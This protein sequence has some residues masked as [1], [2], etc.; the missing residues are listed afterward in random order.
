MKDI[1][2]NAVEQ[3][4]KRRAQK[5]ASSI[6]DIT[7]QNTLL[8][9]ENRGFKEALYH[10]QKRR[11]RGKQLFEEFRAQEGGG[12]IFFSPNKIQA[13]KELQIQ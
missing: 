9:I 2:R 5:I 1:V 7:T 8:K 6:V 10:E 13:A 3:S 12:A 11:K 4:D